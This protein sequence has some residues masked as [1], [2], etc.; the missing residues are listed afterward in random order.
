M[1][2]FLISE[3]KNNINEKYIND[4]LFNVLFGTTNGT[5]GKER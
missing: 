3:F 4:N 2:D 1:V 5:R